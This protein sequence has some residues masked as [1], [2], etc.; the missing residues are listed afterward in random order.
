MKKMTEKKEPKGEE[1]KESKMPS[2]MQKS[3]E[4]KEGAHGKVM[5]KGKK[6]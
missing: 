1:K 4:K 3:V 6:C 5:K 2:W